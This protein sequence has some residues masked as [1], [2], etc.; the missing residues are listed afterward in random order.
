MDSVLQVST[1]INDSLP[2]LWQRIAIAI[3]IGLLIGVE[4]ERKK[5]EGEKSFAGIRTYPLISI[6]GFLA[7]L[8]SS[9]THIATYIVIFFAFSNLVAITYYFSSKKGGLGG[10]NEITLLLIFLLGSLVYWDL[11]LLSAA[12]AVVLLTFLTLKSEFHSFAGKIEQED[13][14]ATIKFAIITIIV[15]PLLPNETFGPF[16]VL[17]PQKI[18]YMVILIA[19]ISFVGYVLFK[20]I[21]TKRGIQLLSI[22]GGMASST[23]LTLSFTHQSKHIKNY[24][25]S[26]ASGIILASTIM[27]PRILIIIFI[28]SKEL[29]GA[30]LVPVLIFT[31]V[32]ITVSMFLWRRSATSAMEEVKISN[33]FSLM[34]AFKFGLLFALILFVSSAAKYYLGNQG[35]YL[36]SMFAG[37]ANPDAITLSVADMFG[38]TITAKVAATSIVIAFT[39]NSIVKAGIAF[40]LGSEELK[41]YTLIGFSYIVGILLVYLLFV[42]I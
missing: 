5:K 37:F 22:L 40:F 32:G 6:L 15:L 9:F 12:L 27:F 35:L 25:R 42:F 34:I 10:T 3:L 1:Q 14:F 30:L 24:S 2:M 16:N 28:I 39:A 19:S 38:K 4:R 13:L 11:K 23:A 7:A 18:W 21:G 20:L 31:L 17:N 29:A 33:P 26:L 41:K 8:I 36:T